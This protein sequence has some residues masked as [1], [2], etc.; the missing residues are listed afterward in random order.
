MSTSKTLKI[1]YLKTI[2]I[3]NN[4]SNGRGFA[5][6]YDIAVGRAGRLY[7]LNRCD[8]DRREFIRVGIF[9]L[10]EEYIGEFGYGYGDGDGQMVWPVAISFDSKKRLLVTDEYNHRVSIFTETGEF[11]RKW[12][13]FGKS[14]GEFNGPAGIGIDTRDNVYIADQNNHRI[15]K[16]SI[17][18]RFIGQ[19][20]EFGTRKGQFDLPWGICVDSNNDVYVADWRNDRVQ[21]FDQDGVFIAEFGSSGTST[22][23]LS[24]PTG[25]AVD[26]EGVIYIADWGN[27]RV[28]LFNQ[29]GESLKVLRGEATLS[30]W[31]KDFFN[32][33]PDEVETRELSNLVPKLD[34]APSDAYHISS[35]TEPF[36]WGPVSV[37][38]D[39]ND[40]LYVVE[41]NRHRIQVYQKEA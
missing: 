5:N 36:F 4:G 34:H 33:N 37:T 7:A 22:G 27:E 20:G 12:G 30:L 8:P 41:T 35:Q 32:S 28:Q 21:K 29:S 24:R 2:G 23:Y 14:A 26:R 10:E 17:E 39:N 40:R 16:Y 18:G 3:T 25:V 6:P 31:A 11:V 9:N 38:V 1:K 13:V 15:Q 19:W